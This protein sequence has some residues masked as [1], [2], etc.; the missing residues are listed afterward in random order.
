VLVVGN[1]RS[2]QGVRPSAWEEARSGTPNDPL[3]FNLSAVGCGPVL[4]L[5]LVRRALADGFRPAV[6]LLEYWPP[7][8]RQDGAF[9][10]VTRYDPRRYR[11]DD[12]AVLRDYYPEPGA[13]DRWMLA[14]R[15]NIFTEN[16]AGLSAQLDS[17]LQ[18]RARRHDLGWSGLDDWGWLPGMDPHPDDVETRRKLTD[19]IRKNFGGQLSGCTIHPDSGRALRETVAVA[20]AHGARVGFVYMPESPEFQSRYSPELE[21]SAR[22]FL[23]TLCRDL[24]VPVVD[25]RDWMDERYLADGFHLSRTGAAVFTAKFGPAIAATFPPV[26]GKP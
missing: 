12:R 1:S 6:V 18:L 21:G 23:A 14:S 16:R 13:A 26:G 17:D 3:V 24:A 7:F 22:E 10:D 15:V 9:G 8:L 11:W 4:Q 2:A 20:R 5:I 19:S 25:A